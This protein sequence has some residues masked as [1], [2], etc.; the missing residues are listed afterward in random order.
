MRN[1]LRTALLAAV[2]GLAAGWALGQ[3]ENAVGRPIAFDEVVRHNPIDPKT[4]AAMTPVARG[5]F[6]TVNVWQLT[7]NIPAH[8]HRAHEEIVIVRSG[9]GTVRIGDQTHTLQAG[10]LLLIPK[11]T[12]H[13]VRATGDRPF[14]GIS[15][16]GPAFDGQDRVFVEE[17]R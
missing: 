17:K 9:T 5:E 11:N 3:G 12:I 16:F 14:R 10:D 4:G 6:A 8:F 1:T 7:S 15:V 13:S 2:L